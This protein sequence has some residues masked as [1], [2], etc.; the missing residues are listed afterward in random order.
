M[1][2]KKGR[3]QRTLRQVRV[4]SLEIGSGILDSER[5]QTYDIAR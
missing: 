2:G 1:K 4:G 3:D 5:F